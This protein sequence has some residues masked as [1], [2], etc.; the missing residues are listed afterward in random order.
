MIH[1]A[2]PD[3]DTS[4]I[5]KIMKRLLTDEPKKDAK[6]RKWWMLTPEQK[7]IWITATKKDVPAYMH[8]NG[9]ELSY[10]MTRTCT[11]PTM[12]AYHSNSPPP[13]PPPPLS[14]SELLYVV[15]LV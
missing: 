13:P 9:P 6:P 12:P 15:T 7:R 14:C 11:T 8:G 10:A 3:A 1:P 5:E 4:D 2:G